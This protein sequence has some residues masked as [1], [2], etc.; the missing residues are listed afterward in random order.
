MAYFPVDEASAFD[1]PCHYLLIE[2]NGSSGPCGNESRMSHVLETEHGSNASRDFQCSDRF[3]TFVQRDARRTKR[4]SRTLFECSFNHFTFNVQ[5]EPKFMY[6]TE[7]Q[8]R[9]RTTFQLTGMRKF[10]IEL[11]PVDEY[12]K[13]KDEIEEA[14]SRLLKTSQPKRWSST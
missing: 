10:T 9:Y 12:V 1:T 8:H 11:G 6:N 14:L 13:E 7:P 5:H 3:H 4:F 2:S